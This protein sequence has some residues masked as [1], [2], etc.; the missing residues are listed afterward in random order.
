MNTVIENEDLSNEEVAE[1]IENNETK[2]KFQSFG[3]TKQPT[4]LKVSQRLG[5][6]PKGA[7]RM[8]SGDESANRIFN[9]Q[10]Q[11]LEEEINNLK[12]G[13]FGK[14]TNVFKMAGTLGGS[15]KQ[16]E[17]A[18]AIIDPDSKEVVVAT[19][20]IK[21]VSLAH[22]VRVLQNKPAEPEAETWVKVES[23]MHEANRKDNTDH[24]TNIDEDD[25]NLVM[26][27]FKSKNEN[28]YNF[29][30]KAGEAFQKSIYKLC[31]ETYS[32][33]GVPKK[34]LGYSTETAVEE[35]GEKRGPG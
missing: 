22:C 13:K 28:A 1:K 4:K 11:E 7:C 8:D 34:I 24:E 33:R 18:Y 30:T 19:D 6:G 2:I 21:R 32:G 17:E 35:E 20:Q 26:K 3:K 15:K 27:K 23:E 16:R 10:S 5:T 31:K 25:F 14:V 9:R 29:P 12:T